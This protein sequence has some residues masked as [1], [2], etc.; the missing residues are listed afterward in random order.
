MSRGH[1][2][3]PP[4]AACL[5]L[6]SSVKPVE[7]VDVRVMPLVGFPD[8]SVV[9]SSNSIRASAA[10]G[11]KAAGNDAMSAFV[12]RKSWLRTSIWLWTCASEMFCAAPL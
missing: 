5:T 3:A 6:L 2:S 12:L 4:F 10:S 8:G 1:A 7:V 11:W 9:A